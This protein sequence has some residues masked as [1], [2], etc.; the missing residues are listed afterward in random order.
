MGNDSGD[1]DERSA[2]RGGALR[3]DAARWHDWN[4]RI[5]RARLLGPFAR[6]TIAEIRFKRAPRSLPFT[7][8]Q[9]EDERVFTDGTRLPGARLGHEHRFE[10]VDGKT[11]ILHRLFL[12]GAAERLWALLV[13]AQMRA[14]VRSFVARER[15][16][17]EASAG[18]GPP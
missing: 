18:G 9:L 17:A 1:P 4:D 3:S 5:E 7:I 16:L 10:P 8:T 13:G 14:A 2:G 6:G 15:E 11:R 12:D